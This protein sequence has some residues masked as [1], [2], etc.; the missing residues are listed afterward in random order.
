MTLFRRT[1]AVTIGTLRVEAPMRVA[2]EIERST[3]PQP[4]KA[5]VRV[6]NLT[7]EHQAQ[8]EQAAAAQVIVEA[9]FVGDRG[10]E[11]IFR[12][13]LFRAR[14]GKPPTS[15]TEYST[16]DAVTQVEARDGGRAYQR[17]RVARSFEAG[18]RIATVVRACAEALGVGPGNVEEVAAA[19]RADTGDDTLPDG[20]VLSG[21][22]AHEL[23]RL[24]AGFGL[25]WSVQHGQL[26]VLRRGE[27][28]QTQAVLLTPETGLVGAPEVATRGRVRATALLTSELWPGRRVVLD[29]RRVEGAYTCRSVTYRGDSHG[30][31]WHAEL[32]L[33][34]ARAA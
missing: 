24:L 12:G 5:T 10:A 16:V 33:D 32:E 26:Q 29:S 17:A 6:W 34:P 30:S 23:T 21:F 19:V 8:I 2:F 7:R 14:G 27:A 25:R 20:T 31:D 9:G 1:W 3:R 4:N 22:A 15:V 13:E 18:V 11:T 28:L